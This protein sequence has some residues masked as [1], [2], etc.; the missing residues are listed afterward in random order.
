MSERYHYVRGVNVNT[1]GSD[2][3]KYEDESA[4]PVAVSE[5]PELWMSDNGRTALEVALDLAALDDTTGVIGDAID[6]L[7]TWQPDALAPAEPVESE[8]VAIYQSRSPTDW[9]GWKDI[10][11][12]DFENRNPHPPYPIG[13]QHEYEYRI[14]YTHPTEPEDSGE[15]LGWISVPHKA[16]EPTEEKST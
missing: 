16:A 8:P 9:A 1:S 10:T 2:G 5:E 14:V 3:V 13:K 15:D 12:D 11:K 6:L 4:P 7:A